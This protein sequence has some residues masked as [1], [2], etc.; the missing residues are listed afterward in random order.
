MSL[1]AKKG[2]PKL[3]LPSLTDDQSGDAQESA[4]MDTPSD[5]PGL[6]PSSSESS[7]DGGRRRPRPSG[8]R[9]PIPSRTQ[10]VAPPENQLPPQGMYT[11]CE[12]DLDT[13][14]ELGM[15]SGG[16][17]FRVLHKSTQTV[18]AKKIIHQMDM[19]LSKEIVRELQILNK[20]QSPHIIAFY[21]AYQ[22]QG[23][24][25]ICMEYVRSWLCD[26]LILTIADGRWIA[27]KDHQGGGQVTRKDYRK[28][29]R[30]RVARAGLPLRKTPH[31]PSRC[32]F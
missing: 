12:A 15:G 4:G 25:C 3:S 11:L 16:T 31:R 29:C 8:I 19:N 18:M 14:E 21:G 5:L 22:N 32:V 27:R 20:C 7:L 24:I 2:F 23:E 10:P 1:R 30:G 9:L 13:L 28:D 17:V 6:T 26:C